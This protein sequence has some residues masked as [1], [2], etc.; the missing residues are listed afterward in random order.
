MFKNHCETPG[1][2][3]ETNII[4]ALCMVLRLSAEL[5]ENGEISLQHCLL[6]MNLEAYASMSFSIRCYFCCLSDYS[7]CLLSEMTIMIYLA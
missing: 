7:Y 3:C 6:A 1:Q 5:E 4:C 2:M